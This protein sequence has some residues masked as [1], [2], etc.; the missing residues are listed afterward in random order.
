MW[1]IQSPEMAESRAA[2]AWRGAM[3]TEDKPTRPGTPGRRHV[4]QPHAGAPA[5]L[6]SPTKHH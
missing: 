1:P 4:P 2:V 5:Q 6:R 3:Q